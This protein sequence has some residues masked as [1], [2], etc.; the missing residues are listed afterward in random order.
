MLTAAILDT[1]QN[2]EALDQDQLP[3][4]PER[5][6]NRADAGVER[7]GRS[8]KTGGG[9]EGGACFSELGGF[10]GFPLFRHGRKL[11]A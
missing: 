10:S 9:S 5:A 1:A 7:R 11:I 3:I 2:N 4:C 8:A 6:A